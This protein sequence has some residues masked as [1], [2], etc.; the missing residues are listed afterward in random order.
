MANLHFCMAFIFLLTSFV[1]VAQENTLWC[2]TNSHHHSIIMER[3][4]ENKA[5][6]HHTPI[7]F[8]NTRYVPIKFHLMARAD[9]SGMIPQE[10]VLQLLCLLNEDFEPL[11]MQFYIKDGFNYILNDLAYEEH[12]SN[13][14]VLSFHKRTDALNIFIPEDATPPNQSGPGVVLGYY[15]P[16]NDWLVID[17]GEIGKSGLTVPHEMGHFFSLPHPFVGWE[18][19]PWDVNIHGNPVNQQTSPDGQTPVELADG[20][21]CENAGDKICDTAADYLFGFGW[22]NCNFSTSVEDRNG[23]VL[24]PDEKLWMNY[25]FSCNDDD[26]YFTDMQQQLMLQDLDSDRRAYLRPGYTPNQS[27]ITTAPTPLSPVEEEELPFYNSINLGWSEVESAD[28]YLLQIALLP[29]FSG[30]LI[31]Y[32][33]VV[34]GTNQTVETLDSNRTYYW[35]V[36]PFNE[37]YTCTDYSSTGS[38]KTGGERSTLSNELVGAFE[39]LKNPLSTNE[40]IQISIQANADFEGN[41]KLYNMNGQEVRQYG[42]RSFNRGTTATYDFPTDNIATGIHFLC[43]DTGSDILY[44]KVLIHP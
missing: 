27:I 31:V 13:L 20:S 33:E 5:T 9:G 39:L 40:P 16:S 36:L 29:T 8:R 10:R 28:A 18:D 44:K 34:N 19:Q 14:E 32:N 11:G 43:L 1:A 22:E 2:G 7:S 17:K 41:L 4:T 30:A 25:F 23:D 3:L 21:N 26:Y 15:D 12:S 24:N 6:L 38:F 37:L 42:K 35:R